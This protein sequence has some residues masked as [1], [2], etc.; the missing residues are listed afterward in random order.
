MPK[1]VIVIGASGHGRV[2]ADIIRAAHDEFVGFLDDDITLNN[3]LGTVSDYK[4]FDA[5]FVIGIGD[6]AIRKK[7]SELDC[8]WYTAIHPSAVVSTNVVI[9]E[10]SVVMPNAVIN[11]GATIGKHCIINTSAVVEHD[12][13]LQDFV[14]VSV[15]VKLGGTVSIGTSAWIGIGAVVSNNVNICGDCVIGAGAV[16]VKNIEE[17][18]T[19]VGVPARRMTMSNITVKKAGGVKPRNNYALLME[20]AA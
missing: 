10:G 15:G 6:A 12:N 4:Q 3:T 2:I 1:R 18:G 20:V 14:H 8:K 13:C 5:E 11:S 16:V 7:L 19:Y 9:G 17:K